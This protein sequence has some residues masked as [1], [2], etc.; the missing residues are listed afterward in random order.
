MSGV[1][2]LVRS[3]VFTNPEGVAHLYRLSTPLEGHDHVVVSAIGPPY[4]PETYIFASNE[5]GKVTNWGELR[6]SFKGALN[7]AEALRGAGYEVAQ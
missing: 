3:N 2:T 7:H 5:A 6:G 1:A 4:G